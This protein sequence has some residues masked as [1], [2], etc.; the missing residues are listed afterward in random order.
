MPRYRSRT[1][2]NSRS[3]A[4]A[5]SFWCAADHGHLNDLR[6]MVVRDVDAA[7]GLI[8]IDFPN[9]PSHLAVNDVMLAARRAAQDT[10]GWKTA[11]ARPRKVTTALRA[12]AA[13]TT[14]AAKGAVHD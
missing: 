8:E 11:I 7:G 4:G 14:S 1:T 10:T 3:M 12:Y 5:C 9:R 2:T 6:Q 13:R